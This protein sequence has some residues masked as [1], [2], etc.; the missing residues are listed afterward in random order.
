MAATYTKRHTSGRLIRNASFVARVLLLGLVGCFPWTAFTQTLNAPATAQN[1]NGQ[2]WNNGSNQPLSGNQNQTLNGTPNQILNGNPIQGTMS[3]EAVILFLERHPELLTAAKVKMAQTTGVDASTISDQAIFVRIQ[4]DPV[5]AAQIIAQLRKLGYNLVSATGDQAPGQTLNPSQFGSPFG[6]AQSPN[7]GQAPGT[8][9]PYVP[10]QGIPFGQGQAGAYP[11]AGTP[12]QAQG[13]NPAAMMGGQPCPAGFIPQLSN[14]GT[15]PQAAPNTQFPSMQ[16]PS[17]QFPSVNPQ[18]MMAAAQPVIVCLPST[19]YAATPGFSTPQPLVQQRTVPYPYVLSLPDLYSQMI[20]PP[21]PTRFGQEV[22]LLGTGNADSLPMDLPA[23][24]DYVLGPGDVLNI[25]IWGSQSNTLSVIVDRQG[26]VAL[27]EAGTVEV[28]GLTI[29]AAQRA[30]QKSLHTQF[31]DMHVEI[32]LGRVRTVRVYVVGDVQRPGAYD[33]S[34]LSTPLNAL[35]AAGGPTDVGSLRILRHYR[36]KEL[37]SDI[38]L[39][40]FLLRGVRSSTER[41][42]PG[43]TVLVPPVGPQVTVNGMVRRPAIYELRGG[44]TLQ[45]IV[46]LAGGVMVSASLE[47]ISVERI[48]AHQRRTML[49]ATLSPKNESSPTVATAAAAGLKLVSQLANEQDATK[50]SSFHMQDGDNVLVR[51][52]LPYNEAA[53][54]LD[55]HVFRPGKYP[56]RDGMTVNDVLHSYQ[57]V[58]PEPAETAELVSLVPPDYRPMTTIL[59]LTQILNGRAVVRL[60][61]F[62]VI[63][64]F[65]RYELD[66]PTVSIYGDVIR[67]GDYPL[68]KGMT[69]SALVNMAGGFRRSAYLKSADLAS[70]TVQDGKRALLRNSTVDLEKAMHGDESADVV[71]QPGDVLGIRQITAWQD[72]GSSV[73]LQGEVGHPGTYGIVPGERLS[74]LVKRAG[75]F[76][77]TAY[78]A[79]AELD[80]VLVRQIQEKTREDLIDRLQSQDLS[81]AMASGTS[82]SPQDQAD[83]FQM[84][85]AQQQS[86]L[87]ALR[88]LQPTGRVVININPDV[89]SWEN[90][91]QDVELRAD[92]TIIIPKR[93]QFVVVSGQVYNPSALAFMPNRS[94]GWYLHLAGGATQMANKKDIYIVRANGAVVSRGNSFS[95]SVLSTRLHPGDSIVVP[96]K[97][98]GTPAWKTILALSQ[99]MVAPA[100]IAYTAVK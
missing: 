19:A 33:I 61:P 74:T 1:S 28:S 27:P 9:Q 44:E 11:Q 80:R 57:D 76:L 82:S 38:D 50:V 100:L 54:Y 63:R 41:L 81:S 96:E 98:I 7:G 24:A 36:G 10:S 93:N 34:S 78:P 51:P 4:E 17:T 58:M 64:V 5:L 92:D 48:D 69:V 43:D 29:D 83:M 99:A 71:L 84:V 62:D 79:G 16:G 97:L 42:L 32:S 21:K 60:H 70:Y 22:F 90:T 47:E 85:R 75:G 53:V 56:F 35:Y 37:V 91:P 30:I 68:S 18:P 31:R 14:P 40:D 25:N 20:E 23:G 67:P 12:L 94:A 52:I 55:G 3:A 86:A 15:M 66:P 45:E 13:Y 95:G 89:A 87:T 73:T 46:D 39:Y 8:F 65:S 6:A 77:E 72:I 49:Q 59:N 88:N 26:Q 2:G